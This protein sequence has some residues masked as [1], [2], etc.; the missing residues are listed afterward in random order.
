MLNTTTENSKNI[1]LPA[2]SRNVRLQDYS[3]MRLGGVASYAVGVSNRLELTA[4]LE[5]AGHQNLEVIMMG[6]GSNIIWR[7]EGFQGLLI[8]NQ[9]KRYEVFEEDETN[10]YIT[11]GAG[12]NWD[13]IVAKTV[14]LGLTGI[15]ALSIIPGTCG[16][17]PVQNVGAYGQEIA[18]SLVSVEAYDTN[19]SEYLNIPA[20][21]CGF[22]YRTSRFKTADRGRFYITAITL[23]LMKSDPEPP[24][25]GSLQ[26]YF[27]EHTI[28]KFRPAVIREAVIA[29]RSDR[30]PDPRKVANNGSFF[31]NPIVSEN[32]FVQLQADFPDI[33][34]WII[35]TGSENNSEDGFDN[36]IKIPAAWLIEHTGFKDFHDPETGMATWP[37]QPLVLINEHA[38]STADLLRF[39]QKIVDAVQSKFHIVLEQEPELLPKYTL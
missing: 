32:E 37:S 39:R 20:S 7:D 38:T 30:L 28:T 8:V 34:H 2:I 4:A 24:F 15:E 25:Y 12:E 31:A 14:E 22:G 16:A 5:W 27:D 17:T 3:T 23:H 36:N 26:R 6:S 21:E 29:I 10:T 11:A 18:Q 33:P 35:T 13:E 9:M 1:Q 19:V